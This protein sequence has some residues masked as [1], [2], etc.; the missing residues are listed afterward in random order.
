M[1]Q[2]TFDRNNNGPTSGYELISPPQSPSLYDKKAVSFFPAFNKQS[3]SNNAIMKAINSMKKPPSDKIS[4]ELWIDKVVFYNLNQQQEHILE[5]SR[6]DK[7]YQNQRPNEK[8][9]HL[10]HLNKS[11]N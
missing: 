11:Q 5:S 2:A 10:E 4:L 3:D 7:K 9:T 6:S 1:E 8:Q